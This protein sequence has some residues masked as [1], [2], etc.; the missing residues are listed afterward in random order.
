MAK[1]LPLVQIPRTDLRVSA[2]CYGTAE[3]KDRPGL[4]VAALY[5]QFRAAG[6]NFFDSAHVYSFWR[7]AL[8]EPERILG[9][10]VRQERRRED[11]VVATKGGHYSIRGKY[12]RPDRYCSPETIRADLT[13]SLERLQLDYVDLYY[14]HRDDTRVPV[15]ELI[16]ALAGEVSAGRIRYF[17]GSNWSRK[18][19]AAAN[20]YAQRTGKP[21][22]VA[23]QPLWN[24]AHL[25][26]PDN[27]DHTH[28][29]LNDDDAEIAWYRE[30]QTAVV[31]FAPTANGLFADP[32]KK[33]KRQFDNAITR[34]RLEAAQAIAREI[35]ATPNQVALA[36]L[37][38]HDFPVIPILGT[39]N[40]EHLADALNGAQI[41]LDAAQ[42][43]RL[44]SGTA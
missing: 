32:E 43:E 33:M 8:G 10:F 21:G 2:F 20:A 7:G 26:P 44:V 30:T 9:R 18:R 12:E 25:V 17:A 6:G 23:S 1:T 11:V 27:W 22:F 4:P 14:L 5:E 38:A 15:P 39:N 42:R 40:P 37:R 28:Q 34:R 36:W 29:V 41:T 24:L 35:G 31:P 3:W 19:F 13:E 16:D